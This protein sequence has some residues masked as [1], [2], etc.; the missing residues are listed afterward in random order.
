MKFLSDDLYHQ[1]HEQEQAAIAAKK[2]E[3]AETP[4]NAPGV[5]AHLPVL[6][7]KK[8]INIF[9]NPKR[10]GKLSRT[11]AATA[12]A[13]QQKSRSSTTTTTTPTIK[14]VVEKVRDYS[15]R[16]KR[17]AAVENTFKVPDLEEIRHPRSGKKAKR[18]FPML[19]DTYCRDNVYT[20]TTFQLDPADVQRMKKRKLKQQQQEEEDDIFGD[21][22][23][24]AKRQ[25]LRPSALDATDRGILRPVSNPED[26]DDQ[27]LIWFLPDEE[28][29]KRLVEQK[30][31]G[32]DPSKLTSEVR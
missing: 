25:K 20:V 17:V 22:Q 12:A 30:T 4:G 29:T 18:I 1:L 15:T 23:E 3:K 21:S 6:S 24:T 28:G 9:H 27:Y 16:E 19:P 26:E 13:G 7:Q 11:A 8:S 5:A 14:R 2:V 31:E 10:Q 32:P